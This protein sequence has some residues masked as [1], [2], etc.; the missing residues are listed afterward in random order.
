MIARKHGP[1]I[2]QPRS[3]LGPSHGHIFR[4][5]FVSTTAGRT[6]DWCARWHG[7]ARPSGRTRSPLGSGKACADCSICADPDI[8]V[9]FIV[10][11]FRRLRT[12]SDGRVAPNAGMARENRVRGPRSAARSAP[13]RRDDRAVGTPAR[14]T[15]PPWGEPAPACREAVRR[16]PRTGLTGAEGAGPART[17]PVPHS[18]LAGPAR[19]AVE[20]PEAR[21]RTRRRRSWPDPRR[22]LRTPEGPTPERPPLGTTP[23]D[24]QRTADANTARSIPYHIPARPRRFDQGN[25]GVVRAR[26]PGPR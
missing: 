22:S 5:A 3:C 25:T 7:A 6:G 9:A 4:I 23:A 2:R 26:P 21:S 16:G 8:T 13:P 24:R 1:P 19:P 20:A 12:L 14:T 15:H 17:R 10:N 18:V 11:A